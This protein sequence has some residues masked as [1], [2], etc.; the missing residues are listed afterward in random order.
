M[1][2]GRDSGGVALPSSKVPENSLK[3]ALMLILGFIL[4]V[5]GFF[6]PAAWLG[7]L[8]IAIYMIAS[9]KSRRADEIEG[10]V[11]R[12]IRAGQDY[13]HFPELYYEAARGYAVEK[14]ATSADQ[15][16]ASATI[17]VEGRAYFVVFSRGVDGG[18]SIGWEDKRSVEDKI[19][20]VIKR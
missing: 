12:M 8:G 10:R 3:D 1:L 5:V 9:R 6:F 4:L 16:G 11:K 19:L 7:L 13:A 18:T 14:G 17:V 20:G 2:S 15:D